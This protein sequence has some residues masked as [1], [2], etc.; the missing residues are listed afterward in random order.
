MV[1]G[2]GVV[3]GANRGNY[4]WGVVK[5]CAWDALLRDQSRSKHSPPML[6]SASLTEFCL[7]V[8]CEPKGHKWADWEFEEYAKTHTESV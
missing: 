4:V 7:A 5:G 6:Q 8:V 3:T 1:Q 2:Y